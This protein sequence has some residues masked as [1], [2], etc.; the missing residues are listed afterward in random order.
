MYGSE[1]HKTIHVVGAYVYDG[2]STFVEHRG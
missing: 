1:I 2:L